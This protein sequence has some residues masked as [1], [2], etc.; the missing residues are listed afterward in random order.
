M[1]DWHGARIVVTGGAGFVGSALVSLLLEAGA[2]VTVLDNFSRGQNVRSGAHS[3]TGDAGDLGTCLKTFQGAD[4]VFNL[5]ATV[6]GV[7]YNLTAHVEMFGEN[8]R[9]QMVAPLAAA[10]MKV[11]RFLQVSSVCVYAPEHNHPCLE[12][13]GHAGE[14]VAANAG[15]SWSKRMGERMAQWA[16]LEHLVI[17]RPSN[18][19][20]P[21]DYFDDKAH[22]IPA[23]IKKALDPAC[24]AVHLHGSGTEVREFLYV[25]DVARGMAHAL[26]H[27]MPGAVYNLGTNGRT[28]VSIH[29]LARQILNAAQVQK[30]IVT[31]PDADSGDVSRWSDCTRIE[32]L[33]WRAETELQAGLAETI[34][35]Y[36]H[37]RA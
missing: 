33:G 19:Y 26:L 24:E 7:I 18:I 4:A 5:A 3:V 37:Q 34:R 10:Q 8:L 36:R 21:G 6:A 2:H 16:H 22:V 27:G 35:W 31:H 17:V 20:G 23:L 30:P 14:P 28:A 11:P 32:S 12:E 25:E 1:S 29:V 13:F 15:Y 9:L